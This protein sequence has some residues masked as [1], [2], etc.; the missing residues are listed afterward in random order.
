[1]SK[2]PDTGSHWFNTTHISHETQFQ[3][4]KMFSKTVKHT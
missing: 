1:L 3:L 4:Y 2:K